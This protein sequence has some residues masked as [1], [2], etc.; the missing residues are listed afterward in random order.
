MHF[1]EVI[2]GWLGWCPDA[3]V[4]PASQPGLSVPQHGNPA[5][6]PESGS[7]G[8]G[9]IGRGKDIAA[10]S[11][12]ILA[13]NGRLFWFSF[14]MF[15][16][17]IAMVVTDRY[18]R[19][20]SGITT[21]PGAMDSSAVLW[22][23]LTFAAAFIGHFVFFMLAAGLVICVPQILQGNPVSVR[24]GVSR[25]WNYRRPVAGWTLVGA[26]LWIS[27]GV[28]ACG[29][30]L[31]TLFA[32]PAMVLDTKDL[33]TALRESVAVFRR[34]WVETYVSFGS[35]L[36]ISIGLVV[37]MLFSIGQVGYAY[38]PMTEDMLAIVIRV[39]VYGFM[40]IG[41]VVMGIAT[42]ILSMQEKP[43]SGAQMKIADRFCRENRDPIA[44]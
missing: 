37:V 33:V 39:V 6:L 22:G 27:A 1:A 42:V 21:V 11:M 26:L 7:P 44:E 20:V 15:L 43:G 8:S 13:R 17:F 10:A 3:Q 19:E 36:L 5:I 12:K 40:A 34:M 2:R 35:I 31:V 29:F 18:I 9:R 4:F 25:A 24:E 16:V 41:L 30:Y 23:A 38:V 32:L 28:F 14:L